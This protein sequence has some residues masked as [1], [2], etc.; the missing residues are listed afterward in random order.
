MLTKLTKKGELIYFSVVEKE[1]D[2][3]V[4]FN[5]RLFVYL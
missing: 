4:K 5:E 3:G 2:K 1:S